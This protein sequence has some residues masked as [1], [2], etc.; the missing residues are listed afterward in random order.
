MPA[1]ADVVV[2][3]DAATAAHCMG[4]AAPANRSGLESLSL[5]A[6][7]DGRLGVQHAG[8]ARAQGGVLLNRGR[9]VVVLLR[10]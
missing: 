5:R 9:H 2:R 1:R 4:K 6:R 10:R 3:L 8:Q 7:L